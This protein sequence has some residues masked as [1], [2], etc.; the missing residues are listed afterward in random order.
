MA[1]EAKGTTGP[2]GG[3][4]GQRC[5]AWTRAKCP[6][7]CLCFAHSIPDGYCSHSRIQ[8]TRALRSQ[9]GQENGDTEKETISDE[10]DMGKEVGEWEEGGQGDQLV[11][12]C[13]GLS[14]F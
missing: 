11:L 1:G 9:E 4:M 2:G 7:P 5:G 6:A 3:E 10:K 12:V 8:E 13:S 14:E